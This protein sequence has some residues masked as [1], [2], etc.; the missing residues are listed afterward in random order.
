MIR[1]RDDQRPLYDGSKRTKEGLE[2][3][4]SKY[5]LLLISD[6]DLPP[7]ELNILMLVYSFRSRNQEYEVLWLPILDQT[8]TLT[9]SQET[10]FYGLRNSMP[11]YS[12]DH[13]SLVD[14]VAIRFIRQEWKFEH[15][16]MAVVLDHQGKPSNLDAL[17]MMWIWGSMA[18]PFTIAR[19]GHLWAE[20][21]WNIDLLADA[22]DPR[23][24][25]WV[26]VPKFVHSLAT[27]I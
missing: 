10:L 27:Q 22:I 20:S 12:V 11:W 16:P 7:E 2:V 3:L 15:M 24:P 18:F 23:I 25:E 9:L 19:E 4:K 8:T 21:S 26:C 14:P 1:S 5:I 17:P 6:L 13:P